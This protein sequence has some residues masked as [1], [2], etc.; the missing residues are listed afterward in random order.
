MESES[1]SDSGES[2]AERWIAEYDATYN[3][4]LIAEQK[5]NLNNDI[6]FPVDIAHHQVIAFAKAMDEVL[7]D[8]DHK[9]G[10]GEDMCSKQYLRS[11]LVEELGEYFGRLATFIDDIPSGHSDIH[12]VELAKKELVDIANF[13][14]MLWDRS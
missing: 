13:A 14:M 5:Q 9:G 7:C 4:K 8:N 3:G 10:W 1:N 12:D 2:R 11:R 6:S